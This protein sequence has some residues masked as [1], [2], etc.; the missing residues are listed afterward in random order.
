MPNLQSHMRLKV[1]SS[2]PHACTPLTFITNLSPKSQPMDPNHQ[3]ILCYGSVI[4]ASERQ[5]TSGFDYQEKD[6][7]VIQHLE[8]RN[9]DTFIITLPPPPPATDPSFRS[10]PGGSLD[11]LGKGKI[12]AAQSCT[13]LYTK[14]HKPL[15]CTIQINRGNFYLIIR[16]K[17]LENT[18]FMSPLFLL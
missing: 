3:F 2:K 11:N 13:A 12:E 9:Q 5:P 16:K 18:N 8:I 14:I 1:W 4:L 6:L 7:D 10:N 15:L 17:Y